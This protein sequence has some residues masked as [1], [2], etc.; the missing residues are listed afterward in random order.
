MTMMGQCPRC[1]GPRVIGRKCNVCEPEHRLDATDAA[2]V[3]RMVPRDNMPNAELIGLLERMLEN[4]KSGEMVGIAVACV[5]ANDSISWGN[6]AGCS[7]HRQL[8]AITHLQHGF[9]AKELG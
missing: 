5:W 7:Q 6:S 3:L 1:H 8:A 4:A 9:W 2:P